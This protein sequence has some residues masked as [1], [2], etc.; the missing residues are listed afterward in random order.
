MFR[1]L[2]EQGD[3]TSGTPAVTPPATE[4]VSTPEPK[5]P[6]PKPDK[7]E[8]GK[9]KTPSMDEMKAEIAKLKKT[10]GEQ[11]NQIGE[12]KKSTSTLEQELQSH[13]GLMEA[14]KKNP[15][16]TLKSLA[17]AANVNLGEKPAV[18]PSI[19]GDPTADPGGLQKYLDMLVGNK[20]AEAMQP[21]NAM[22]N[23]MEEQNLANRFGESWD[24]KARVREANLTAIRA[25]Q[26]TPM[27]LAQIVSEFQDFPNQLAA[28]KE[29]GREE[30][31]EEL[32]KKALEHV[33]DTAGADHPGGKPG[34]EQTAVTAAEKLK[35]AAWG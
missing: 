27:H 2:L 16:A 29:A 15:S 12:Y 8:G 28:A 25:G 17:S 9:E 13:R 4:P 18:D 23:T 3:G 24:Q 20:F 11:G 5:T 6:E 31:R 1:K 14:L 26:F 21:M 35:D 10:V 7:G 19:I 33:E 34:E 30:L 22:L 32:R